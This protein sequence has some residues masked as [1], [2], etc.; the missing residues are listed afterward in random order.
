DTL[1]RTRARHRCPAADDHAVRLRVPRRLRPALPGVRA[2]VRRHRHVALADLLPV[3]PVVD[4]RGGAGSALRRLGR[5]RVASEAAVDRPA[6]HLRRL[7]PLGGRPVVRVL[8]GRLRSVG[9]GWGARFG[10]AG[11]AGLRRAG[12]ARCRRPIRADHGPGPGRPAGG[13]RCLH[14]PGGARSRPGRLRGR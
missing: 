9:C 8:R 6:A 1:T 11:G 12:A 13:H 5:R 3:R 7:R 4:H 2:A 10:R 14:R